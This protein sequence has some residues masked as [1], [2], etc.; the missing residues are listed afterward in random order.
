VALPPHFAKY[1]SLI[2]YL[3]GELMREAD[4]TTPPDTTPAASIH[5]HDQ[6]QHSNGHM[7]PAS[8]ATL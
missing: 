1:D 6:E 4:M 8:G 7:S 5:R 2:D 3:V